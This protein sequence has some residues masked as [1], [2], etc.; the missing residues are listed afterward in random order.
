MVSLHHRKIFLAFLSKFCFARD[1]TKRC[2]GRLV[3]LLAFLTRKF[4]K[5][6]DS[7]P[8]KPDTSQPKTQTAQTL[9]PA[10]PPFLGTGSNSYSVSGGPVIVKKYTVAASSVPTSASFP[11]L[12]ERVETQPSTA[13]MVD[14]DATAGTPPDL[15]NLPAEHSHGHDPQHSIRGRGLVNLSFGNL[16][17]ASIRSRASDRFSIITTSRSRD[18]LR[19]AHSPSQDPVTIHRRFGHDPVDRR[20]VSPGS[21]RSRASDRPHD[22]TRATVDQSSRPPRGVHRQFG[23]GPST[24]PSRERPTRPN[25]PDDPVRGNPENI[26]TNLPSLNPPP[27]NGIRRELSQTSFVVDVQNPSTESLP[28]SPTTD[29]IGD[30]TFAMGSAA[31]HSSPHSPADQRDEPVLGPPTPSDAA[32]PT[33]RFVRPI[34]SDQ[35]LRYNRAA[36]LQV[37]YTFLSPL[38]YISLQTS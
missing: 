8:G 25:T 14:S 32:V 33:G 13:P 37:E 5:W 31:A 30:E 3:L 35:T 20:S 23:R 7:R 26:P 29:P 24:S 11:S 27:T 16:S 1:Y 9:E 36:L 18:S 6:R 22:S 12:H 17:A 28:I 10:E 38:S 15:A 34:N 2:L 21:T 4:S 19:A